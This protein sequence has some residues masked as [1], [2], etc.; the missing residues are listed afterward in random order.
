MHGFPVRR[1]R[2][3]AGLAYRLLI[4]LVVRDQRGDLLGS[5]VVTGQPLDHPARVE[6]GAVDVPAGLAVPLD[7]HDDGAGAAG[8]PG[9]AITSAA[10]PG[11]P[12][13]P[14]VAGG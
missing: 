14:Q 3:Q 9:H 6:R 10:S 11:G 1:P 4:P 2:D 12:P 7:A 5:D 8:N 13:R